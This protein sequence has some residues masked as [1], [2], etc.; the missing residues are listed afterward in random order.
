[1]DICKNSDYMTQAFL[2]QVAILVQT[3]TSEFFNW[4]GRCCLYPITGSAVLLLLAGNCLPYHKPKLLITKDSKKAL[5]LSRF[6][7][8][9]Q[10]GDSAYTYPWG[11]PKPT[12][13]VDSQLHQMHLTHPT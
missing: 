11:I 1:M 3:I 10:V 6:P 7:L 4:T 13:L 12:T 8:R 2:A 9:C 5:G